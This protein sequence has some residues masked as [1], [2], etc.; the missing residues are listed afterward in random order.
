M[1]LSFHHFGLACDN[2]PQT[3]DFLRRNGML[4]QHGP[5]VY[6][7]LQNADLCWCETVTGPAVEL[8]SGQVV[9]GLVKKGIHLYHSCW[10]TSEL[11][12]SIADLQ[13]QGA[14]LLTEVKPAILFA[15]RRVAFLATGIGLIELLEKPPA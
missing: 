3:I 15:G 11:D 6:D 8:I 5:I 10:E 7:P 2:I 4:A 13:Q 12:R 9:A 14:V 1:S